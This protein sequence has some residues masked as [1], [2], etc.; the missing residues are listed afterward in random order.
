MRVERRRPIS[1]AVRATVLLAATMGLRATLVGAQGGPPLVTD[2]PGTPG[3]GR[4]ELNLSFEADETGGGTG[5][6]APRADLNVGAG[7]RVQLKAEMPWRVA[8]EADGPAESGLGNLNVGVKWRF[9]DRGDDGLTVSTFPQLTFASSQEAS[10][11]GV[12][13][14]GTSVLLPIEVAWPLGPVHLNADA[15]WE[16]VEGVSSFLFG[17]AVSR[18]ARPW[19]ELL[20]ECHGESDTRFA[21]VGLLCGFGARGELGPP[22]SLIAAWAWGVAGPADRRPERRIYAGVQLRR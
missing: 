16:R 19:L 15:G 3:S 8:T 5:Y 6:D 1:A 7:P 13:D 14:S 22:A 12:A 2:D 9:V 21:G 17:L 11:K 10:A 18:L 20:G 4:V